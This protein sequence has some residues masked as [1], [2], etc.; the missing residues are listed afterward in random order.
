MDLKSCACSR[1]GSWWTAL[2]G[3]GSL[4]ARRRSGLLV[5]TIGSFLNVFCDASLTFCCILRRFLICKIDPKLCP[6][7]TWG[8]PRGLPGASRGA[9]WA[10]F[11][12]QLTIDENF[13]GFWEAPGTSREAPGDPEGR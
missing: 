4:A 3:A 7:G 12:M 11:E 2:R 8:V 1:R 6:G 13:E 9:V 10:R 5:T